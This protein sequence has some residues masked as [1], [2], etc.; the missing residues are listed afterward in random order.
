[1]HTLKYI[2]FIFLLACFTLPLFNCSGTAESEDLL[3]ELQHAED[4]MWVKPDSALTILKNMQ[5]PSKSDR[6]QYSAWCML[7]TQAQIKNGIL[8]SDDSLIKIAYDYF[9]DDKNSYHRALAA[10]YRGMVAYHAGKD[11]VALHSFLE[12]EQ[13]IPQIKS[14][15]LPNQIYYW[16]GVVYLYR[17]MFDYAITA[18]QK[19]YE[20]CA[21]NKDTLNMGFALRNTARAYVKNNDSDNALYWYDKALSL[22]EY[23]TNKW[24]KSDILREMGTMYIAKSEIQKAKDVLWQVYNSDLKKNDLSESDQ[25]P[26]YLD[27]ARLY[28]K[29]NNADSASFF[30]NKAL[31]T[32]GINIYQTGIAYDKLREIHQDITKDYKQALY[33]GQKYWETEDSIRRR[34]MEESMVEMRE[35]YNQV[36]VINDRNQAIIERN[37]T[38]KIAMSVGIV[39]LSLIMLYQFKLIAKNRE[40]R[41]K[42][43]KVKGLLLQI[44]ENRQL[45]ALNEEEIESLKEQNEIESNRLESELQ[46]KNHE[47]AEEID[48]LQKELKT[49][50]DNHVGKNSYEDL[51]ERLIRKQDREEFLTLQV[52]NRLPLIAELHKKPRRIEDYEWSLIYKTCNEYFDLFVVRLKK[53]IPALSPAEL[54]LCCLIKLRFSIYYMSEMLCIDSKSVSRRK[55]R[56]K[57]HL[58]K[59]EAGKDI[60]SLDSWIREY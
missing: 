32:K 37:Q 19:Q 41:N 57:E 10:H 52:L 33:Y 34:G 53:A 7:M 43:M 58:L 18:Y 45:I 28:V 1:M 49:Q 20:L 23:S 35:K 50:Q 5:I 26:N 22:S 42:E 4:I 36:K 40:L 55:T 21:A 12:A 24:L 59:T 9:K 46:K 60:I 11:S 38:I 29:L 51:S 3:P 31:E 30:L 48:R 17:S 27:L 47:L 15:Y 39:L 6:L 13:Y 25:I 54:Q 8:V 14:Y 56:L 16:Q 2:F 44:Q